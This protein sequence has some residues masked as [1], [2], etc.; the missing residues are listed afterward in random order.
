MK[1]EGKSHSINYENVQVDT[2]YGN[3]KQSTIAYEMEENLNDILDKLSEI[4][5][6]MISSITTWIFWQWNSWLVCWNIYHQ[7][8]CNWEKQRS[9]ILEWLKTIHVSDDCISNND[10]S[11]SKINEVAEETSSD[12]N[13]DYENCSCDVSE[14]TTI[15]SG[16]N[17]IKRNISSINKRNGQS[18]NTRWLPSNALTH[19]KRNSWS[20]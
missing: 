18:W 13:H 4:S 3:D 16:F 6:E 14:K 20:K 9:N 5:S 19:F 17:W 10:E 11:N 15:G 7:K 12:H 2:L 8:K 1:I